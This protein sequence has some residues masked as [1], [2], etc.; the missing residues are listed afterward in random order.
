MRTA[1]AKGLAKAVKA[2]FTFVLYLAIGAAVGMSLFLAYMLV[3]PGETKVP[4]L[5]GMD[6]E[7]AVKVVE[8]AGLKVGQIHG[9]GTVDHTY[10]YAG[11]IVRKGREITLFLSDPPEITV[12]DLTGVPKE[13][14]QQILNAMNFK[15]R[16]TEIPYRGTDGRVLGVYPPV[17]SKLKQGSEVSLLIDSGE[18]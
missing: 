14:A 10:P 3:R 9:T 12:P 5:M 7:T 8:R 17:G 6:L 18:P 1:Q 11:E 13:T 2:T 4:D 15:V 16:I